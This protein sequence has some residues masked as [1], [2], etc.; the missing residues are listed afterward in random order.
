[1]K[2]FSICCASAERRAAW[3]VVAVLLLLLSGGPLAAKKPVDPDELFNPL[4][5]V[6]YSHWLVGP[7]VQI[8]SEKEVE[9]YLS[10]TSD[11]EAAAFIKAF[12]DRRNADTPIF[13]KTPRQI[14]DLRSEEADKRFTEA[15]YP[16]HR[17]DRGTILILYGE[18]EEIVFESPQKVG[19]PTLEVWKYGSDSE[20]GLDGEKPK[21]R[22]RFYKDG[23]LTVFYTG[24]KRRGD[25]RD[26]T[27][28]RF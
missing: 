5:G 25:A 22:Y 13:Q 23:E 17:T 16:G 26:R 2:N 8:A 19:H 28:R 14:Y 10:L 6:E 20:P 9:E 27:R 4:L 7:I 11:E 1:M 21:K 18:P 12:W 15:A 3:I 24:Q